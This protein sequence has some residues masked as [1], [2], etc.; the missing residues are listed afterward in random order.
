MICFL[1]VNGDGG[2]EE[3]GLRVCA[4]CQV[5]FKDCQRASVLPANV[6]T[7]PITIRCVEMYWTAE[8]QCICRLFL[9]I[10]RNRM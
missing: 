6:K 2:G 10:G 9:P 7:E 1:S 8:G 3:P 4:V 5:K